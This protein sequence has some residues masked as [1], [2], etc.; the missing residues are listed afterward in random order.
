MINTCSLPQG[1]KLSW[2]PDSLQKTQQRNL[3]F[4]WRTWHCLCCPHH[5]EVGLGSLQGEAKKGPRPFPQGLF[6]PQ[7]LRILF[8]PL[9]VQFLSMRRQQ[10]TTRDDA[11]LKWRGW[12][13]FAR[14][15]PHLQDLLA[16][17][18]ENC[19]IFNQRPYLRKPGWVRTRVSNLRGPEGGQ[20]SD[21]EG[22]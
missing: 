10:W 9:K 14:L 15:L 21:Q 8:L 13:H 19:V 12:D 4:P 2:K 11:N 7:A 6:P 5:K 17:S 1:Q 18:L 22:D 16:Q 20:D 3:F